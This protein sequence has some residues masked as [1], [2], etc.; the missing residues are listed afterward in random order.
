MGGVEEGGCV[1]VDEDFC[2]LFLGGLVGGC[3][4]YLGVQVEALCFG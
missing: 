2:E 1:G 4:D 3:V